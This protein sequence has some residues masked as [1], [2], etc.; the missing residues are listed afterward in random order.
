MKQ[1]VQGIRSGDTQVR[2]VPAPRPGAGTA[3]VRTAVSL[4]SAGTERAVLE[5]S[6]KSLLGKARARPDLVRQTWNKLRREGLSATLNAVRGRL[7]QPLALGYSSSGVIVALGEGVQ[8]YQVGDRVACAGGGH[9]VHAEFAVVPVNLL[10]RL[11]EVVG[12]EAGAFAT[13]GAIALHGFRL[14]EPQVGE[15]VAVVGLGLLGQL[16]AGVA[17]AAGCQVLGIDLLPER[18]ELARRLGA[19]AVTREQSEQFADNW[20]SGRGCD[21]VLICAQS[22]GGD[23]INLAAQIARD[24]GRVVALGDVG[25]DLPRRVFYQ[26]ELQF[27]VS[28]SY[29]PGRYD[30]AY[31]EAGHDY[32]M[33]YVRWT[34]GR[35]LQAFVDLL[36]AGEFQVESLISH[37]FPVQAA[38]Q[39]YALLAGSQQENY[40]AVLLTYPGAQQAEHPSRRLPLREA[41]RRGADTVR[42]GVL[43]AGNFANS[44][45][46][47]MLRKLPDL[48]LVG[49]AA[50]SGITAQDGGKRFGFQYAATDES[51]ILS[52]ERVN[53]LAIFT[54][55]DLH[56]RQ[57]AEGLRSG[58]HV[59]CEKPLA[60]DEEGLDGVAEALAQATGLLT[61]GFN[62]RFAPLAVRLHQF[63]AETG[64][65]LMLTCR[66]NAGRL[67]EDHWLL[68]PAQGGRLIGE[69]C[70]FIDLLT[71][72]A[73][74]PPVEIQAY[75]LEQDRQDGTVLHLRFA[76][77]SQGTIAYAAGGDPAVSKERIETFGGGRTAILDDFRRLEL[78][79]GGR[80]RVYRSRGRQ[81]KGHRGLWA[82]FVGAIRTGGPPPIPYA[83]LLAV[84]HAA[85][86]AEESRRTGQPVRV[87]QPPL[88]D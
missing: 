11:P 46:L 1:V 64:A 17:R 60:I 2:E 44:V 84:T 55:H 35:N 41:P 30:P 39:A 81:D 33:G 53:T 58:K 54:R 42:L 69:A 83:E 28:R 77:G 18:V 43:G 76:G 85:L 19:D 68:D 88:Q 48:E 22:A 32:P 67:P 21:A 49:L 20:S 13:L 37:R 9:A 61:V 10:A 31:E 23:P 26:K 78:A 15:R 80:R 62:R 4:V 45:A 87:A 47:P 56:A 52:D 66:V 74:S 73:D 6:E 24:R 71:F 79:S 82:A 29:G 34:E 40:L 51:E 50:A 59:F 8:G 70:H 14:A 27:V 72:L 63:L 57:A 16:A 86:A 12:F 3:L 75:G 5:F 36:E 25:L 7:D 65:P 38:D